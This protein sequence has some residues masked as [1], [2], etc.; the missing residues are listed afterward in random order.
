L[1]G[2][3]L[4]VQIARRLESCL[5]TSDI[6][7]RLGGDE[8][9]ILLDEFDDTEDAFTIVERIQQSLKEPFELSGREVFTSASIGIALSN[10]AYTKPEELLRDADIAMYRAKGAGRARYQIFNQAMHEQASVRLQ[11]ETEIRRAVERGEFRMFYQPI[12]EIQSGKTIGF[13]SLVRWQHPERGIVSPDDFIPIAEETGQI[14]PLGEWVLRES[15]RQFREW[16]SE[17]IA[18][19]NLTISVNL[20]CKQFM[21]SD[22]VERITA[23]LQETQLNAECLRLEITESHLIEDSELAVTIIKRLRDIGVKLSIDDFG[24]GY[25]SLSYL[26]RLPIDFLKID[27]SFVSR[28]LTNNENSEIVQTVITLAKNLG[29]E[30]IAEGIET[31][32]QAEQL[33]KLNCRF[34]QG[35]FYSKPV[36][37]EKARDIINAAQFANEIFEDEPILSLEIAG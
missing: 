1:E 22:L 35:Y 3:K 20:S 21:Q 7:A 11:L 26:H 37:A 24:T 23:I 19:E 34:G 32:E 8:F 31:I 6:V 28:M 30:V 5:R 29:I 16:Q 10:A 18:D 2:D 25:S 15:C 13:E 17:K 27:R 36:N 4:L 12:I 33:R 9:T 14:I